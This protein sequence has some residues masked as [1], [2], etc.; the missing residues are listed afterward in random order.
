MLQVSKF[1]LVHLIFV[2]G[3]GVKL[4]SIQDRDY[5]EKCNNEQVSYGTFHAILILVDLCL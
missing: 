1:I 2:Y 5:K 3:N 4:Q